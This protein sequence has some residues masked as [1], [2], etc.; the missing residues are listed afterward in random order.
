MSTQPK[1]GN[2]PPELPPN[3]Q[4]RFVDDHRPALR[5]GRYAVTVEHA[6]DLDGTARTFGK[7]A[8]VGAQGGRILDFLVHGEKLSLP[9]EAVHARFPPP[10]S[11]GPWAHD[12][13]HIVLER[14]TLPW[15]RTPR[16]KTDDPEPPPWLA[17]LLLTEDEAARCKLSVVQAKEL[18]TA[19]DEPETGGP[20]S[21]PL[22]PGTTLPA[23]DDGQDPVTVL[24]VPWSLLRGLLPT[25]SDLEA[26]AHVRQVEIPPPVGGVTDSPPSDPAPAEAPPADPED[27]PD[28]AVVLGNRIPPA[29]KRCV[30]HLVSVE[31]RYTDAYGLNPRQRALP[32]GAK[33]LEPLFQDARKTSDSWDRL[34]LR[35]GAKPTLAR[36]KSS[37]TTFF[38]SVPKIAG[39]RFMIDPYFTAGGA[40]PDRLHFILDGSDHN[41]GAVEL[42][43]TGGRKR[44]PDGKAHATARVTYRF[45]DGAAT[46]LP[47][48]KLTD[49]T[50]GPKVIQQ[51]QT[52]KTA[53]DSWQ[54]VVFDSESTHAASVKV[55]TREWTA[56]VGNMDSAAVESLAKT[57]LYPAWGDRFGLAGVRYVGGRMNLGSAGHVRVELWRTGGA[58]EAASTPAPADVVAAGQKTGKTA[59]AQVKADIT[60]LPPEPE[61]LS[62]YRT[63]GV[64][65]VPEILHG[66]RLVR[67]VS[68][69]HWSFVTT[70]EGPVGTQTGKRRGFAEVFLGLN[71]APPADTNLPAA[72]GVQLAGVQRTGNAVPPEFH[73]PVPATLTRADGNR[74]SG[75]VEA[76]TR[77]YLRSGYV[78][79]PHRFRDGSRGVS[80]Y[81]GP[82]LPFGSP[83]VKLDPIVRAPDELLIWNAELG[84]LD[85]SY[86]AAWELGRLLALE[87]KRHS[88]RL[89][90]WKRAHA[91]T[92]AHERQRLDLALLPLIRETPTVGGLTQELTDWFQQLA[93]LE[94]VPF[95]YLVPDERLLP[96]ESL[97]F[98]EVDGAWIEC[99]LDGAFSIGRVLGRDRLGDQERKR[100]L[101]KRPTIA[102]VVLRSSAVTAWPGLITDG[103][104]CSDAS[105]N[106]TDTDLIAAAHPDSLKDGERVRYPKLEPLV[107]DRRDDVLL[108]LFKVPDGQALRF[109]DFHLHPKTLHFGF[110]RSPQQAAARGVPAIPAGTLVKELRD[111]ATGRAVMRNVPA[112]GGGSAS[113]VPE[114]LAWIPAQNPSQRAAAGSTVAMAALFDEIDGCVGRSHGFGAGAFAL[115]MVDSPPLARFLRP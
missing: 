63:K 106:R 72:G 49:K 88:R 110:E 10:G 14:S 109:V 31:E 89:Y 114:T 56:W 87:D 15:E 40:P 29:D 68:L 34:L 55:E 21:S 81:R 38:T 84:M 113:Q 104:T 19:V 96:Q 57:L 92:L 65:R 105:W 23:D 93:R 70:A 41:L 103:Y 71:A 85:A 79:L 94:T 8:T 43:W 66:N 59:P 101:V 54:A 75:D 76:A 6:T 20:A 78:P 115:Q 42:T 16:A 5:A 62:G 12:L 22:W 80:W 107:R 48:L 50:W 28:V 9:P 1:P 27:D 83:Q 74:L 91:R 52:A 60:F 44:G 90:E 77:S 18:E 97:R 61:F 2:A 51:L 25:Y 53:P 4:L 95:S 112:V 98:V 39:L 35:D 11:V 17:V 33:T 30:A 58:A 36:N 73:L 100:W 37:T 24:D 46:G 64:K 26:M 86:A 69:A 67:L 47:K 32:A 45:R 3:A 111:P 108:V 99:L 13:P 7:A 102:G 82:L